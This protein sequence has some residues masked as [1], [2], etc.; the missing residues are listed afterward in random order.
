MEKKKPDFAMGRRLTNYEYTHAKS[1]HLPP[2]RP[3]KSGLRNMHTPTR[4][5]LMPGDITSGHVKKKK[6]SFWANRFLFFFVTISSRPLRRR[7]RAALG[8]AARP[9]RTAAR[10]FDLVLGVFGAWRAHR[11]APTGPKKSAS[12]GRGGPRERDIRPNTQYP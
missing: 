10:A 4:Y 8:A 7:A 3:D 6:R 1:P 12:T 9:S 11:H 2:P 5:I